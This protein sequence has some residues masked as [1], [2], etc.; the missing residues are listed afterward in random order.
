M[1]GMLVDSNV[2]YLP[3]APVAEA[4]AEREWPTMG[5]R[6]R[7]A[8]WRLRLALAEV[9]GILRR[10]RRFQPDAHAEFAELEVVR[11]SRRSRPA[12]II[13]LDSARRRLR[14]E[15]RA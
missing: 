13:D 5:T 15:P 4:I 9:R 6:L 8:W 3:V 14:P 12:R 1:N 11:V 10:P 2:Y 7:N